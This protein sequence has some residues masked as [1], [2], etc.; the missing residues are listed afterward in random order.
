MSIVSVPCWRYSCK[1]R[2]FL[3]R[4]LLGGFTDH[5]FCQRKESYSLGLCICVLVVSLACKPS[6][7]FEWGNEYRQ[8]VLSLECD[9]LSG[10]SNSPSGVSSSLSRVSGSLRGV[11]SQ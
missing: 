1:S 5:D 6:L 2:H 7:Y 9:S 4:H 3:R 11:M 10:V 8:L